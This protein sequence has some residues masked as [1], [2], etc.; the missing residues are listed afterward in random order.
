M[1]FSTTALDGHALAAGDE[2]GIVTVLDTSLSLRDQM[3]SPSLPRF[4]AHDNA[5]FDVVWLRND[6]ALATAGGDATIRVFDL[7]TSTRVAL[8]RGHTGSAK[9]VRSCPSAPEVLFSAGRDGSILGYDL[10]TPTVRQTTSPGAQDGPGRRGIGLDGALRRNSSADAYH[11]PVVQISRPHSHVEAAPVVCSVGRKRRRV[12]NEPAV[13]ASSVT[14]LVFSPTAPMH[15]Y[16]AGA[17]GSVKMWDIRRLPSVKG[18]GET[19]RAH[20]VRQNPA[21][22]ERALASLVPGDEPRRDREQWNRRPRGIACVDVDAS[23]RRLLASSTDSSIYVYDTA[24][25]G[26]GYDR[27]LTGHK[28]TSFYIRARFAPDG[29]FVVSGSADSKAYVW[30]LSRRATRGIAKPLLV[31]DGH[32]GGETSAVDWCKTDALKIATCADDSTAKIWSV[33]GSDPRAPEYDCADDDA[34]SSNVLVARQW[35][36]TKAEQRPPRR[37][38]SPGPCP[39]RLRE[40]DIRSLLASTP[41]ASRD[42]GAYKGCPHVRDGPDE[43]GEEFMTMS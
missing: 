18:A 34:F 4:T 24:C 14:S 39:S 2:E 43:H 29:A 32:G 5:I 16:S 40:Q 13:R 23:G 17:D 30:D 42:R 37:L 10:R 11:V 20:R 26:Q 31:L 9:C 22:D 28:H 7:K 36:A 15:L 1:S 12:S 3:Q 41:C 21:L 27:I 19:A 38:V 25:L 8:L 33:P 6:S 35:D